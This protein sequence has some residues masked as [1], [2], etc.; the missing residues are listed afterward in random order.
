MYHLFSGSFDEKDNF[1]ISLSEYHD[2]DNEKSIRKLQ[3]YSETPKSLN[4]VRF[5]F[6]F[7]AC[8]VIES[9]VNKQFTKI[10]SLISK[11]FNC[12]SNIDFEIKNI[13]IIFYKYQEY[14]RKDETV[15]TLIFPIIVSFSDN[16]K[17][18][19]ILRK[20]IE[21][22]KLSN[23]FNY[24]SIKDV[25]YNVWKHETEEFKKKYN[26]VFYRFCT[27]SNNRKYELIEIKQDDKTF[28][29]SDYLL[30]NTVDL[31]FKCEYFNL[32]DISVLKTFERKRELELIYSKDK[33]KSYNPKELN[34]EMKIICNELFNEIIDYL[35]IINKKIIERYKEATDLYYLTLNFDDDE[36]AYLLT[37]DICDIQNKKEETKISVNIIN[38]VFEKYDFIIQELIKYKQ[39]KYENIIK[40]YETTVERF[41]SYDQE[42]EDEDNGVINE[43]DKKIIEWRRQNI[44]ERIEEDKI[45]IERL[46]TKI[47][48]NKKNLNDYFI[49]N[50]NTELYNRFLSCFYNLVQINEFDLKRFIKDKKLNLEELK[51]IV[52]I[53]K[54]YE[55]E[56]I[57]FE[58]TSLSIDDVKEQ[59][60]EYI[61]TLTDIFKFFKL[62]LPYLNI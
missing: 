15:Y 49:S 43:K 3:I 50:I 42:D 36:E 21:N 2:L 19:Q 31:D 56:N 33:I 6:S 24:P 41:K 38:K 17:I 44:K 4:F 40:D 53:L 34:E 26:I 12:Y 8:S 47:K 13:R 39:K 37:L 45:E 25:I 16:E 30:Y 55:E 48:N 59:Q 54:D 14:N 20:T 29:V 7:S 58:Y 57:D 18:N 28:K 27:N 52:Q 46:K 32:N 23:Y 11:F 5:N 61:K 9:E 60:K 10:L 22:N 62:V 1:N 35:K 51:F